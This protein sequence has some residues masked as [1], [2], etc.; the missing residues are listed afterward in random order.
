MELLPEFRLLRPHSIDEVIE[1]RAGHPNA[2]VLAGGTDLVPNM[3]RGL[4]EADLVIDL[5]GC[6]ELARIEADGDG[7]TVGA[8]VTLARLAADDRVRRRWRALAEA[9]GAVAGPTQRA[10]AT[11]G[12][13]ICLDTRCIFYN[14]SEWWRRSNDYCLKYRGEICHVVPTS[15]R[16]Y[17]TYNGDLAAAL[18][19][20]DAEVEIAGPSGRRRTTLDEL[21]VDDGMNHIAL[22]SDEVLTA[23]HL[24]A[25]TKGLAARYE[26]IRVRGS[27]DFP[28]AGVAIGL[29]LERGLVSELRVGLT[30]TNPHPLLIDAGETLAGSALDSAALDELER[31][32]QKRVSPVRT[33]LIAPQYRRRAVA[34]LA[35]RLALDL[36]AA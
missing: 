33:G 3:R 8:T 2:R 29:R 36:A 19:V 28:L 10:M 27:I 9:A 21:L 11:V 12:G 31:M 30:G 5:S 17:A 35:A 1:A 26:K 15:K 16:C 13:N 34:A 18:L 20:Y 22:A 7:L 6:E 14:Q 4:V 24:P 32:V 25:R 23:V